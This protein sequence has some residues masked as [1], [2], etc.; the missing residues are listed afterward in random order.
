MNS[1]EQAI[2]A[3][4]TIWIAAV[5]AGEIER[6]LGMITDDLV[7]VSSGQEPCGRE[8]FIRVF[9]DAHRTVRIDCRSELKEVV[10]VGDVAYS[11]ARDTL[12]VTPLDGGDAARL[13]GHRMTVYRK[14]PDGAWRMAR[15]MH[16]L[17]PVKA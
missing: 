13:A 16:T 12:A 8:G 15:D 1:D 17:M 10:V 5:N 14:Q 4:N 11:R 2:H 9:T 3:F 6:L 7:L